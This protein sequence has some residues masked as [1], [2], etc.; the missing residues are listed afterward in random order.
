MNTARFLAAFAPGLIAYSA[1]YVLSRGFYA[2]SD[3]RTPFLL[4]LVI[5]A[6]NAGLSAAAYF[7]LPPRWAVTG[8][9]AAC[10]IARCRAVSHGGTRWAARRSP[11]SWCK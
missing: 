8:M 7:L 4:N 6:L 2:L 1:Q 11:C 9:A 10:S 5:A 3:T